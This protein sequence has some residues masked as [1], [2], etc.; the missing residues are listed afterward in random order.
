M[1]ITACGQLSRPALPSIP[2]IERQFLDR[3]GRV[4]QRF[5]DATPFTS[6]DAVFHHLLAAFPSDSR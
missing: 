1:L 2:G 6:W 4:V 3:D 5:P